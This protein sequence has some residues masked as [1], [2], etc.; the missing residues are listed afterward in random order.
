[1]G[2]IGSLPMLFTGFITGM[3]E[4]LMLAWV[5]KDPLIGFFIDEKMNVN[6]MF[7]LA[8]RA[9]SGATVF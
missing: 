2:N 6:F 1:M 7:K 3:Q 9:K 8:V 4:I 5:T